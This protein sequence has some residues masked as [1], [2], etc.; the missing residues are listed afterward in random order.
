[1]AYLQHRLKLDLVDAANTI[2]NF[3]GMCSYTPLLGAFVADA[4]IGRYATI[5]I[6][7]TIYVAALFVMVIEAKLPSTKPP[8]CKKHDCLGYL[9]AAF[10]LIAIAAGGVRPNAPSFGADQFD[11]HNPVE[12]KQLF[13]YFNW[14]YFF[15]V[16]AMVT[17][18]TLLVYIQNTFGW[19]WGF[20]IPAVGMVVAVA[21]FWAGS[22]LYRK[23]S[24]AGSPFT[25]L[26]QVVVAVCRKWRVDIPNDPRELFNNEVP[27]TGAGGITLRHTMQYRFLDRA[28]TIVDGEHHGSEKIDPWRLCPVSHVEELKSLLRMTPVWATGIPIFVAWSQQSTF[29]IG[30]GYVM[31]L[32]MGSSPHAFKMQP[33]TLPVFSLL[34]M[35]IFLPFYDKLVVPL[36][37]KV[38]RNPRGITFLQRIGV[39]ITFAAS[40]ML[41]AGAVEVKRRRLGFAHP[42]SCFWLIP[43]FCLL[44]LSEAFVTIGYLEFFYDQSPPSMRSMAAAVVWAI[45]GTGNYVST[46]IVA[47]IKRS[48]RTPTND[49]GWLSLTGNLEYFYWVL[50]GC[51]AVDFVAHLLVSTF[52]TYTKPDYADDDD[53]VP[54]AM[55]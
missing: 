15:V 16:A 7:S 54:I 29:W 43:Q 21:L 3:M 5:L 19:V 20:G 4:M 51:L 39:G 30:Q 11:Q 17:S 25:H 9:Y 52:Y 55:I 31:D 32:R 37:A 10:V 12:R 2:T 42:L 41:V 49:Q 14:Y 40:A 48:T 47:L 35:M 34:T 13:S 26:A 6:A 22:P 18:T 44:G 38:T 36:A 50:A 46:A 27:K 33:A 1:M 28:A 24:P 8:H 53:Q 23:I 45:I